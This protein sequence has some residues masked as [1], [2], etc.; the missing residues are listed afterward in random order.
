MQWNIHIISNENEILQHSFFTVLPYDIR[1]HMV[2]TYVIYEIYSGLCLLNQNSVCQ[3]KFSLVFCVKNVD[4][5]WRIIY[6]A[7]VFCKLKSRQALGLL[8][9]VTWH[10]TAISGYGPENGIN[11]SEEPKLKQM[12]GQ[13]RPTINQPLS[14][15]RKHDTRV[16]V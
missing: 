11:A 15:N 4:Y 13:G 8:P 5:Q 14:D 7:R 1:K 2:S 12:V 3:N 16:G 6:F 9:N 10:E